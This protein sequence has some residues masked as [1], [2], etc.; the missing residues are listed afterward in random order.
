MQELDAIAEYLPATHD[1]QLAE[2]DDAAN[3]PA[4]HAA[5]AV[6]VDAPVPAEYKPAAQPLQLA[7]PVIDW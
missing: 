2:P 4:T 7:W 1:E 5:Q 3:V 6:L